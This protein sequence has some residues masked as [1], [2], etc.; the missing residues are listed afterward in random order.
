MGS[1]AHKYVD[2][3][4]FR[5]TLLYNTT[6][7]LHLIQYLLGRIGRRHRHGHS[8]FLRAASWRKG[9]VVLRNSVFCGIC[10]FLILLRVVAFC[11][12]TLHCLQSLTLFS[13]Y[14]RCIA[15]QGGVCGG[16]IRQH[17]HCETA[18]EGQ[19]V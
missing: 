9:I 8:R 14:S 3:I 1:L 7:S 19:R 10:F 18:R 13:L 17:L 16:R 12:V 15:P 2:I 5:R 4:F 11:C 6:I